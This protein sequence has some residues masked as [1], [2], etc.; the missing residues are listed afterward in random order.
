MPWNTIVEPV[1]KII[2]A[3]ALA[4]AAVLTSAIPASAGDGPLDF[5][6][7]Q[8]VNDTSGSESTDSSRT[9]PPTS[10]EDSVSDPRSAL[11]TLV[12]NLTSPN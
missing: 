12:D 11:S 6:I 3:V 7:F 1:M 9:W 8:G 2:A 4:A 10:S 5:G